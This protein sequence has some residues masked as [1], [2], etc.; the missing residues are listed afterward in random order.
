MKRET[1]EKFYKMYSESARPLRIQI[2]V[3]RRCNLSCVH[4]TLGGDTQVENELTARDYEKLI[5]ELRDAGLINIYL[6]GGE[7]LV[8]PEIDDILGMLLE[9]DFWV[10]LQTNGALLD[11]RRVE[12]L[13]HNAEKIKSIAVSLYGATPEVHEAVT[14][15]PGS[16]NNTVNAI[17]ML[18]AAGFRVEVITLLMTLN[19]GE[20]A[21][22]ERLC[23]QWNVK[24]QFNSVLVPNREG[25]SE[26]LRYRLPE[27]LIRRL[28]RP[29][30]TFTYTLSDGDPAD[31]T[32]DRPLD[33]WC[34]MARSTGYLD[35]RGNVLPCSV[36]EM[37]AGNVREQTFGEIW[38][39]SPVFKK[40][41]NLKIGEFECS[42]CRHFPVCRP[43]PGLAYIEH[44]NL[45]A[46]PRE[47]CRIVEQFLG[48]R[49]D[50]CN[51]REKA[52]LETC[53]D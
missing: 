49:E 47:I 50:S 25:S 31:F 28:P 6:T 26:P 43:C 27:D 2:E 30:E 18:T 42:N 41:R 29:W 16:F 9:A 39:D 20:R 32:P 53:A 23:S 45:F 33:A 37:P 38:A 14:R 10:S 12:L 48:R 17:E 13:E 24:Q 4:C 46:A 5:P 1:R 35:S 51:E 36:V 22:I 52:L 34:S 19:F 15:V 8:H 3:T 40:I 44:G 11:T 21:A 7:F